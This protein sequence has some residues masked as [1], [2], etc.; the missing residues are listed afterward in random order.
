MKNSLLKY[1][2]LISIIILVGCVGSTASSNNNTM[3]DQ[4]QKTGNL[5]KFNLVKEIPPL[6]YENYSFN[7]KALVCLKNPISYKNFKYGIFEGCDYQNRGARLLVDMDSRK[8]I[9]EYFPLATFGSYQTYIE[10]GRLLLIKYVADAEV[11]GR[12]GIKIYDLETKKFVFHDS[13]CDFNFLKLLKSQ[14]GEYLFVCSRQVHSDD[15]GEDKIH[16]IRIHKL[17]PKDNQ[18][19]EN[20][21]SY[22]LDIS[23]DQTSLVLYVDENSLYS[24]EISALEENH[25]YKIVKRD[26]LTGEHKQTIAEGLEHGGFNRFDNNNTSRYL[27]LRNTIGVA[28]GTKIIDILTGKQCVIPGETY[29]TDQGDMGYSTDQFLLRSLDGFSVNLYNLS[30]C[31]FSATFLSSNNFIYGWNSNAIFYSENFFLEVVTKTT[32]GSSD[33]VLI[34]DFA[35]NKLDSLSLPLKYNDNHIIRRNRTY[36]FYDL[37]TKTSKLY[38]F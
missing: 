11:H 2:T 22:T 29:P 31:S 25:N 6:L 37:E 32:S 27:L 28:L 7:I 35:G 17:I 36:T 10:F 13:T 24:L 38:T 5:P 1:L 12:S 18:I 19:I 26:L 34:K 23:S 30:D 14:N 33:L 3:V 8:I 21:A 4:A 15:R 16:K 20:F 9:E